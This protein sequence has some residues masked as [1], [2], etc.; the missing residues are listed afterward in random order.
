MS[1]LIVRLVIALLFALFALGQ[2]YG[3][4]VE[5]PVTGEEQ[6]IRL[7]AEDE[8]A[9]GLE[10]RDELTQQFGGLYPSRQVQA[11]VDG[12]GDRLVSQSTAAEAPY[13][14]EFHV[15]NDPATVNAFALPGGQVFITT[16]LLSRMTNEAQL[17]G[18]LG[19]EITHVIA[20][21]GAEHLAKQQLGNFL[22][23][24]VGVAASEDGRTA[25]NAQILAQVVNSLVSLQYGRAD[26]TESDRWGFD[27]MTEAGYNPQGIVEVMR[28]LQEAAGG[29][30]QPEFLSSH[31]DPGNRIRTLQDMIAAEY[32]QGVP[33]QLEMGSD[34]FAVV[35]N[36]LTGG[37]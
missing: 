20:R 31:P 12:V 28:I 11:Y 4:T 37:N 27:F 3:N 7:S 30:G 21:H 34:R 35:R 10:A 16:A 1:K 29:G 8:V 25:G 32:P 17:A 33:A 6:H 14:F 9:L 2:Y 13:P 19:H 18:V 5:N 26:E 36:S 22:M 15:L 24:A 23:V